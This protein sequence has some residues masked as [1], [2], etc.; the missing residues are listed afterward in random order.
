MKNGTFIDGAQ[1]I[2]VNGGSSNIVYGGNVFN[3]SVTVR[4]NSDSLLRLAN[5]VGDDFN[6]SITFEEMSTG[7]LQ[8]AYNGL[9]TLS[10][11]IN[12]TNSANT[13]SFGSGS[14][15][16]VIDG[17]T[18]QSINGNGS[19]PPI[20]S[21]LRLSTS[22]IFTINI[23]LTIT[24]QL[25]FING[26]IN[27]SALFDRFIFFGDNATILTP[28]S[29]TSHVNGPFRKIG[30]DA[31]TFPVGNGTVCAP[32]S[33][34][35]PS[36]TND[37]FTAQYYGNVYSATNVNLSLDHISIKEYWTLD[38]TSGLSN[39][40]VKLSYNSARSGGINSLSDLR[41]SRYNGSAWE[42]TG[43][44]TSIGNNQS[45]TVESNSVVS[46]F[47]PFTLGS[48][49]LLNPLPISLLNFTALR[50]NED[51]LVKWSTSNESNNDYFTVEKSFDGKEWSSIGVL[52]GSENSNG[53]L[54]YELLDVQAKIGIQYYRLKQTDLN[55]VNCFSKIIRINFSNEIS[56]QIKLYPQPVAG[57]LNIEI[58]NNENEDASVSVYNSFG[59]K[60][61]SFENLNGLVFQLDLSKLMHGVYY[62]E[63]NVD[64]VISQNKI[65]KQ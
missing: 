65:I 33:I 30:N 41:V 58:P 4:N 43:N 20:L 22:G 64:G 17:N 47:S 55:G 12:T 37:H 15:W 35:A 42:S 32:I 21:R 45:G 39:V 25:D 3:G 1:L 62:I 31:F 9:N 38:R 10:G 49:S 19:I 29:N 23:P 54:N 60:L 5:S 18:N 28:P 57:V 46:N 52:K 24:N 51:V 7:D 11:D 14:G 61:L 26:I 2:K 8:P 16:I 6:G 27:T 34:S 63:L 50:Q 59:G 44:A 40:Q 13:V 56:N 36:N 53:I 48:A